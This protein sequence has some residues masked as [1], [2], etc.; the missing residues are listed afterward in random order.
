MTRPLSKDMQVVAD[1]LGEEAVDKLINEF[2]GVTVY[3]PKPDSYT[4]EEV[5][6]MLRS[7]SMNIKVAAS[8]LGLSQSKVY[9]ILKEYRKQEIEK[10]QLKLFEDDKY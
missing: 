6:K 8:R 5:I 7:C 1:I 3:I 10:R 9:A 4:T 2:G